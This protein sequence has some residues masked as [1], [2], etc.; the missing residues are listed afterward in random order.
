MPKVKPNKRHRR[1]ERRQIYVHTFFMPTLRGEFLKQDEAGDLI[2]FSSFRINA[3][4]RR[5]GVDGGCP[6]YALNLVRA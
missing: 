1:V 2:R 4:G 6:L 5:E 3:G